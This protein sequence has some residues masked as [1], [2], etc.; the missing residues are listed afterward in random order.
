M[1]GADTGVRPAGASADGILPVI[2]GRLEEVGFRPQALVVPE[3]DLF[4]VGAARLTGRP[5][6][7]RSGQ[8]LFSFV[9]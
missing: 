9:Q 4:G 8:E 7:F 3:R 1:P 2:Q 6:P 5:R